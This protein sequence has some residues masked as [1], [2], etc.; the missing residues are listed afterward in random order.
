MILTRS[1]EE[2]TKLIKKL[3]CRFPFHTNNG[4]FPRWGG[5][6]TQFLLSREMSL[7][8]FFEVLEVK[9]KVGDGGV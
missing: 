2:R 9:E 4:T 6:V 3:L 8:K 1:L 5:P 7:K